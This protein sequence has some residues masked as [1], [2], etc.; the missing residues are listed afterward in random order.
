MAP[1]TTMASPSTTTIAA[2]AAAPRAPER[3]PEDAS[4]STVATGTATTN[5]PA[6]PKHGRK[7]AVISDAEKAPYVE[8]RA[9]P[10]ALEPARPAAKERTVDKR[11]GKLGSSDF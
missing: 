10:P 9:A 5:H 3:L 4:K 8:A 1:S 6:P 11:A 7:T 2:D